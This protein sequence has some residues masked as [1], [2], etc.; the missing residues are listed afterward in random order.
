[1]SEVRTN[2][3]PESKALLSRKQVLILL[4]MVLI[5]LCIYSGMWFV[6]RRGQAVTDSTSVTV[7]EALALRTAYKEALALAL[8][9]QADAQLS[10]VMASW[11]L[12]SGDRLTLSQSA[13]SFQFFAPVAQQVLMVSVDQ[14][15]AQAGPRQA[16]FT[17]PQRLVP[18]WG[19]DSDTLLLSFLGYGGQDFMNA[20]PSANVHLQLTAQEG[21]RATWFVTAVDPLARQ[22]LTVGLDAHSRE[23]VFSEIN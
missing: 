16:V 17:A 11:Q 21:G 2:Q 3:N 18:D 8:D 6:N 23:V 5:N 7:G 10:G 13:W 1:M 20:H 22:S 14:R 15:G 12:A 4:G 9:W 19:L